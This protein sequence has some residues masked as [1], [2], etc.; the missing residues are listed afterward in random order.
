M[1]YQRK[2][3]CVLAH[4]GKIIIIIKAADLIKGTSD[5]NKKNQERDENREE[6]TEGNKTTIKC[7]VWSG[8]NVENN[9]FQF[10]QSKV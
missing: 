3:N 6:E 7:T 8:Q 5:V 4:Q 9:I 2:E 1:Q 10:V